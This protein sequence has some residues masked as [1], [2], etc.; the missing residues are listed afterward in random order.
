MTPVPL[1][2]PIRPAEAAEL[3]R[4][5]FELAGRK[6]LDDELR[7]RIAARSSRLSLVSLRPLFRSLARD[8]I[9]NSTFYLA[10]DGQNGAP[11]L[12]HFAPD[13]APTSA[14]FPKPLL[15]GRMA[16]T[17]INAVPFGPADRAALEAFALR[18]DPAVQPR[19]QGARS[20]LVLDPGPA[21]FE[22]FSGILKRSGKNLAATASSY[23]LA[24]WSAIRAGWRDGWTAGIDLDLETARDT[25]RDCPAYTRFTVATCDLDAA[26]QLHAFIRQTRSAAKITR[27]FDFEL[28]LENAPSPS[29]PSDL[30]AALE[31]LKAA[32]HAAQLIA[33][34]LDAAS[35]LEA[36]G[37]A[38][39][40]QQCVLSLREPWPPFPGRL[41]YRVSGRTEDLDSI[42]AN[43]A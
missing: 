17:V 19:P 10:V 35:D 6:P 7:G 3:A 37:A 15:I 25:V 42:A 41:N 36:L 23:H 13:A 28:S 2:L 4:I 22:A 33:P 34:R 18:V 27:P 1:D 39:R 43:L 16:Q 32:G 40:A 38:A 5:V 31:S 8:P 30:T 26:A 24:L 9:H 12:L 29:T 11:L 21:A 14:V 20:A